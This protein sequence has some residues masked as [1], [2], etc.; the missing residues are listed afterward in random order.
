[1]TNIDAK[2]FNSNLTIRIQSH[3]KKI[4]HDTELVVFQTLKD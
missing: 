3:V 4:I 2:F 1:M